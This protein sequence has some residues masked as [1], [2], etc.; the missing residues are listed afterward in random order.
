LLRRWQEQLQVAA[1]KLK[2]FISALENHDKI[3]REDGP[4]GRLREIEIAE[5]QRNC[6]EARSLKEK[7]EQLEANKKSLAL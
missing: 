1:E 5:I 6:D 4:S 2:S 7:V 3:N